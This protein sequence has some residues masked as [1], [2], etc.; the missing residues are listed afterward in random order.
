MKNS[1]EDLGDKIYELEL[2]DLE[3]ERAVVGSCLEK[4]GHKD[5]G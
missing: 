5:D 1:K 2:A 4:A 3:L